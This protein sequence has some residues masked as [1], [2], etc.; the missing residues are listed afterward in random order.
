MA[1]KHS[2]LFAGLHTG[3]TDFDGTV[4]ATHKNYATLHSCLLYTMLSGDCQ[5]VKWIIMKK[6]EAK[7]VFTVGLGD[8]ELI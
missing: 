5:L 2:H 1:V 3:C 6:R 8:F 4:A 7:L